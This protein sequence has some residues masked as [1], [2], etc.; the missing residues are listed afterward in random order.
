MTDL[1]FLRS[2]GA[3]GRHLGEVDWEATPLGPPE[4]WPRELVSV[5][6]TVLHSRFSMWMAWGPEL[7]FFCNDAYRRDTLGQK[8][9]WALGRPAREVWSEIW[10]DIGPR[11]EHVLQ[12]GDA[13]WDEALL[14]FLQRSGFREESYHTFSYSP[15]WDDEDRVAGMLCVVT[16]DTD[17]VI[18]ERHLRTLSD[19]GAALTGVRT[20]DE[21]AAAAAASLERDQRSL[22]FSLLWLL[23][24]GVPRLAGSSGVPAGSPL[25]ASHELWPLDAV[26]G[27]RAVTVEGLDD[28]VPDLPSGAWDEPSRAA[29]CV[30]FREAD[31]TAVGFL[32]AGLNPVRPVEERYTAFVDLV[33]GQ[34]AAGLSRAAAY[35]A[36]RHRAERL[37]EIDR[38]K[39]AFFTNVSHEF[40]TPLTLLLGPAQDAL[41]DR[42]HALNA[43]QRSRMELIS[44]NGLRLLTLVNDL[45][46][47]SRLESGRLSA[48]F[49]PVD[50]AAETREL[51]E[52]FADAVARA[53]LELVVD[54]TPADQPVWLDRELWAKVVLNLL[55]NAL[56]FTAEGSITVTVRP[57]GDAVELVVS[58]TGIGIAR[59][60]Q[61][62]VFERFA[63]V[64]GVAARTHEGSGIG[65]AL[66]GELVALHGGSVGLDSEPGRGSAFTV[67]LPYGSAHLPAALVA[68]QPSA[69]RAAAERATAYVAEAGRWQSRR[70][71]ADAA[72]R[73]GSRVLVVE[74]NADMRDYV[75]GLLQHD[76]AVEWAADG[77]AGLALALESPPD[78]VLSDVMMPRLDGFGLLAA[79]RADERTADVPV[80]LL[81]A[82][83]GEEATVE[84][85]DAGADDYLVKPFAAP[86]LLARVRAN[87]E[88]DSVRRAAAEQ[89]RAAAAAA[90]EAAAREHRIAD[91]LQASLLPA[92]SFEPD[93]L[94]VA[95]YY[96]AGVEGTQVGGD[97]YDVI[98]LGAGRT[99]LVL[100]DV[101]G[102]GVRAA[103]V[104]GQ[105][106]T[107][108]RAYA[109][110]DLPPADLLELLDGVVRDLGEDQ[111]VT[112]VYAVYDPGE[113]SLVYANAGHLPP[114]L[115]LPGGEV[116]QLPG[117][118]GPPLGA[119]RPGMREQRLAVPADARLLLYTDGLVEHRDSDLDDGISRLTAVLAE[120]VRGRGTVD[121]LPEL[122]VHAML[123]DGPDDDVALLLARVSAA[124]DATP[125]AALHVEPADTAVSTARSFAAR[126]LSGWG[127]G[128]GTTADVV[129][130]TSELVTNAI[131]HGQ[132]PVQLRLRR[133]PSHV[134]LEVRDSAAYYPR[135]L[136]PTTEDEHGRGMQLVSLLASHWGTRPTPGG[137]A[138]WCLVPLGG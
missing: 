42:D 81:S 69:A 82:R 78:L 91:E 97:W 52:A 21:V 87:L 38:A 4:K 133:T 90:Q 44:R 101:M 13:T 56:K 137:K 93:H 127:V 94:E 31:G 136:R 46:D 120:A 17:R 86:E 66:V 8:Y 29:R 110:L 130:L 126:Q 15:L 28:L 118:N 74:D 10:P 99:A 50:L 124:A 111:I 77:E 73:P 61:Q 79:L 95:T 109:R 48:R 19:L 62:R 23:E 83:A 33:A 132:P 47:F 32:V 34:V 72:G 57:A 107:A 20:Q 75:V 71:G 123:P 11:I 60:D 89:A 41:R 128:A 3:V 108:I 43:E 116:Q 59:A 88:L 76:Y 26:R 129:L 98:E 100:G 1:P 65:L 131:V 117:V 138:V 115:V 119:G 113:Q 125:V 27:G 70:S 134:V 85:L 37:A 36:E 30:P 112:C 58:D 9:P 40:R 96:R 6:R 80:V 106:R 51:A 16:E 135:L 25:L 54:C 67:R 92:R 63:R 35:E 14:L 5:V 45:L 68:E 22:P 55:S 114:L 24:D 102:R 39:T 105:L 64:E 104:M 53:G 7:T 49:E 12:T 122:V 121:G 18:G 2:S 84:G 103:A